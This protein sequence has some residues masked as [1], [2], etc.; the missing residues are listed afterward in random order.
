[1]D[2][3]G[4]SALIT[5]GNG[6]IGLA[7]AVA[8]AKRGAKVAITGRRE[9]EGR[10]ALDRIKSAG[11]E[12]IFVRG[13]VANEADVQRMVGETVKAF[14]R[15]D[16]AF[17]NAGVE[18][19]IAVPVAQQSID[20]YRHVFDVNVLGVLFSMKHQIPAMLKNG[21]G[22][23]V[24][25][26]SV[27]GT[28]GMAGASVYCASKNAVIGLTRCAAL[29]VS[30]QGIRVNSVSPAVIETDMY[31][32]FA[33]SVSKA[34]GADAAAYMKSLHPI[35][36][37]GTP[38]EVAEAVLWLCTPGAGFVTGHDLRVDGGATVP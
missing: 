34:T 4:K 7:T 12:A 9:N 13:D 35:G 1:M 18:G 23:I 6:G 26:A 14:G 5:G 16:F 8:F 36:R 2:M 20:N 33:D 29:E 30:A 19:A 22:S 15:L 11:G 38:T 10:A 27:A 25:N 32:R 37:F 17:N 3:Q 24:N 31:E 21:G 28:M